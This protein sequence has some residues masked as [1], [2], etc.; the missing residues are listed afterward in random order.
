V[1]GSVVSRVVSGRWRNATVNEMKEDTIVGLH[2]P[3]TYLFI[4]I[5]M[6]VLVA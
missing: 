1:L 3:Q 2:M 6:L 4:Y 5:D